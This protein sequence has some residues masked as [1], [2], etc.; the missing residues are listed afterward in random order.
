MIVFQ[1][2]TTLQVIFDHLSQ[3]VFFLTKHI[4]YKAIYQISIIT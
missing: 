2:Y 1:L 3:P 4:L